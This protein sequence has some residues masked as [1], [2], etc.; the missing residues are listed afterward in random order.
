MLSFVQQ[1]CLLKFGSWTYDTFR[2]NIVREAPF[3]E[4]D[5]FVGNGEWKL[6]AFPAVRNEIYYVCCPEPYPDITFTLQ[7]QRL[8]L[9][10]YINLSIPCVLITG[11][12]VVKY[13]KQTQEP[14]FSQLIK[15][16]TN[17][18]PALDRKLKKGRIYSRLTS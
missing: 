12:T 15:G 14:F 18:F 5:R 6:I 11:T 17:Y 13:N 10:Y 8:A 3:A 16:P 2:V 1:F 4:T 7:I 9:F